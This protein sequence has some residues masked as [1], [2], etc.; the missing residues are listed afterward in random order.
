MTVAG[1]IASQRTEHGVPVA[2]AC[3]ALE[4]SE[5]WF[6]K[7][8]DRPP[9]ARDRRRLEL[10][11][12][13]PR[14]FDASGGTY[15]SPRVFD[16]L[17]EEGWRVSVNTVA[18]SMARQG[19]VGRAKRRRKN[20]TRPD[21]KARPFPDRLKRDFTASEPDR[22]WCGGYDRDPDRRGQAVSLD[23]DRLVLEET[24]GIRHQ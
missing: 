4:V 15:G 3:R 2:V 8:Q 18:A 12:A 20:L 9:T 17:V 19:L 13:V 21:K 10:D 24:A 5:S 11:A 7:W 1:F 6:Y 22:K 23:S 14:S 16:D